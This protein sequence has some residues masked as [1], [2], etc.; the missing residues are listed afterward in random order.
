MIG[1]HYAALG[2]HGAA[3][4]PLRPMRA[5]LGIIAVALTTTA[6]WLAFNVSHWKHN[7]QDFTSNGQATSDTLLSF[8]EVESLLQG[9]FPEQGL[10]QAKFLAA[11]R[12]ADGVLVG[13][14]IDVFHSAL[15]SASKQ[16]DF[17]SLLLL[18]SSGQ[19]AD[20]SAGDHLKAR[21]AAGATSV[22]KNQARVATAAGHSSGAKSAS[23]SGHGPHVLRAGAGGDGDQAHVDFTPKS[24]LTD[25][26]ARPGP[27]GIL[28]GRCL[29]QTPTTSCRSSSTK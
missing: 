28:Q 12:N 23:S 18:S 20:A 25:V 29:Q 14:E 11:D 5:V 19:S 1:D 22:Q 2:N 3:V 13:Q 27:P 17:L 26:L 24:G 21:N 15:L 9:T 8:S 6:G 4:S 16:P 10:L 7:I